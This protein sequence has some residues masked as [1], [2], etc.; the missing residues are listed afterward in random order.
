MQLRPDISVIIATYNRAY[1]LPDTLAALAAQTMSLDRF[2]VIVVDDGSTDDTCGVVGG[3]A[4]AHRS[5]N[6]RYERHARNRMKPAACNTGVRAARAELVV[7][8]D[9]DIRPVPG[10][11]EAHVSRHRAEN[12]EVS[13]TGLV[14]YPLEWERRSNW[15]R[16]ANDNYRQNANIRRL[17]SGGLPPHRFA[18]GNTSIRR[19]LLLE[20]GLF[21][22]SFR[23]GLDGELG[24][25]LYLAG[26]PLVYEAAA[27]VYHYAEAIQSID[28]TL[29]SFRRYY[30]SDRQLLRQ[31][32][33]GI[34][35]K[36][37][38][39]F[40]EPIDPAVDGRRR[41][42]IKAAVQAIANRR[43]QRHAIALAH[44]IDHIPWL[45]LRPMYQYIMVCEA[46][47]AMAASKGTRR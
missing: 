46:L 10:W 24:A 40:L 6:L 13:V 37:G 7:F 5:L 36:F 25:K 16:F 32:Y 26:V 35:H 17:E 20:V 4:A 9:D 22:E 38:H 15:V 12:R 28:S 18:G 43:L 34:L 1:S 31:R 19:K 23:R 29:R 45:H 44:E 14:L 3:F 33:P 8:T 30:E 41:K 39:W 27:V 21:D 11:L 2:E 47:D 42:L